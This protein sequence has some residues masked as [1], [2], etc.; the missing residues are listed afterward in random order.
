MTRRSYN[1]RQEL[2]FEAYPEIRMIELGSPAP[3]DVPQDV[4][5]DVEVDAWGSHLGVVANDEGYNNDTMARDGKF[6]D[7]TDGAR[8]DDKDQENETIKNLDES[9]I[10]KSDASHLGSASHLVD[11][12]VNKVD[13]IDEINTDENEDDINTDEDEDYVSYLY[14][15]FIYFKS[16]NT[17]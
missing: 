11:D 9:I 17:F 10:T 2:I 5:Q 8:D 12:Q 6:S 4:S 15:Y 14:V 16:L 7:N 13:E 3:Q 1:N